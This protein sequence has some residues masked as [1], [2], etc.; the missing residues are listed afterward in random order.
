MAT[1]FSFCS[2]D[3]P[4]L[5]IIKPKL[6]SRIGPERGFDRRPDDRKLHILASALLG[7][8]GR[9]SP[10]TLNPGFRV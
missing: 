9:P 7:V 6:S 2:F 5:G 1:V 8:S 10:L 3:V 4:F